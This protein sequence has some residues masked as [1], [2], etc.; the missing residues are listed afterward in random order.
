VVSTRLMVEVLDYYQGNPRHK[1]WLMA[2]AE[3][4]NDVTRAAWPSRRELAW[5]AGVS[6]SRASHIAAALIAEGAIKR[7]GDGRGRGHATRYVLMPLNGIV[8]TERTIPA[9]GNV[10]PE[11]T[12]HGG[13][14]D[15]PFLP[16]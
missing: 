13:G 3:H 8:R 1:L 4:A 9:A 11:R 7:D 2:F 10:R 16:E 6:E 12:I 5:R 14:D 15:F